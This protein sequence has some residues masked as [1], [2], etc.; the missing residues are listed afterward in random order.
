[1]SRS[2]C[3]DRRQNEIGQ[4][5]L[6]QRATVGR[7]NE[8]VTSVSHLLY[9]NNSHRVNKSVRYKYSI[10]TYCTVQYTHSRFGRPPKESI[11]QLHSASASPSAAHVYR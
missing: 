1:M 3:Q 7:G 9:R 2:C 8:T 11:D 10:R 6:S 5:E 4:T